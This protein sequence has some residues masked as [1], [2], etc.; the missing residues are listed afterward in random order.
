MVNRFAIGDA[1]MY[2]DKEGVIASRTGDEA[3][4]KFRDGTF[5]FL[6]I[7]ELAPIVYV[8]TLKGDKEEVGCPFCQ[9]PASEI[10][11][12]EEKHLGR[13]FQCNACGARFYK[14]EFAKEVF[15]TI[16]YK[17]IKL[18]KG[19]HVVCPKCKAEK[20]YVEDYDPNKTCR[21]D[22]CGWKWQPKENEIDEDYKSHS[23]D[24]KKR[25]HSAK[26]D[27]CVADVKARGGV[28]SP[29]AVC[30]EQL[31]DESYE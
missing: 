26:W 11:M 4:V 8:S 7:S 12:D 18:S 23:P 28:D 24:L 21:C 5:Q 22:E 31:G 13:A 2:G 25:R 17:K 6:N 19:F 30:T 1:V 10:K 27:R 14:D 3:R 15:A 29:E 20:Y 9:H 16:T